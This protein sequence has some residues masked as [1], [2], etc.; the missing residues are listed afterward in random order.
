VNGGW[1]IKFHDHNGDLDGETEVREISLGQA[2]GAIVVRSSH[3]ASTKTLS[4]PSLGTPWSDLPPLP[5]AQPDYCS[6]IQC[7][8]LWVELQSLN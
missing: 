6:H 1:W 8:P 5:P 7:V 4:S 2:V 3:W